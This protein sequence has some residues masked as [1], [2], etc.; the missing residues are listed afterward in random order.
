MA[1]K[2]LT[3]V[4]VAAVAIGA[5]GCGSKKKS[6]ASTSTSTATSSTSTATHVGAPGAKVSFVKPKNG[7]TQSSTVKVK[8]KVTGFTL[9]PNQVGKP[10]KQGEGH[11]QVV[12][13]NAHRD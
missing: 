7:S 13:N 6:S 11:L 1:R 10:P 8:V 9:A 5:A 12:H 3:L 4:C 2:A